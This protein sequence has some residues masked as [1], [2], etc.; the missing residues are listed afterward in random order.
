MPIILLYYLGRFT[1]YCEVGNEKLKPPPKPYIQFS[2]NMAFLI[3]RN[4]MNIAI[5]IELSLFYFRIMISNNCS[6]ENLLSIR[7]LTII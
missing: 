4:S 3:I 7:F 1:P 6:L 5:V 2:M